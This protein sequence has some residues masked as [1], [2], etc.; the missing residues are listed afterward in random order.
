M[1]WSLLGGPEVERHAEEQETDG[2]LLLK[3]ILKYY[4]GRVWTRIGTSGRLSWTRYEH[5]G[6]IKCEGLS[7][8]SLT[9]LLGKKETYTTDIL[10]P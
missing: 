10:L 5:L 4:T 9:I 1:W 7:T 8:T 6:C 3:W 2:N